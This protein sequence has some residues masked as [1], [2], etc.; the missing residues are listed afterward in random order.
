MSASDFNVQIEL[1]KAAKKHLDRQ[2]DILKRQGKRSAY[3]ALMKVALKIKAEA[4]LRLTGRGHVVT[5]RLKNSIFVQAKDLSKA[6]RAKGN[7]LTYSDKN[8]KTYKSKLSTV[9]LDDYSF[10]VGS[11][12]AYAAT[13]ELGSKP[14][15]IEA[16]NAKG[17]GTP[18]AGYFGKRVNHPG[19]AGD[20]YLYWAMKNVNITQSV[21]KDMR[22]DL[23][24]GAYVKRTKVKGEK[25]L[26]NES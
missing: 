3:W 10:A 5:S 14:H 24:F 16:K 1:D 17:L 23:K 9:T 7:N 25:T 22:D 4:Q 12:V 13:I 6:T 2:F 18:Q 11:N 19:F 20:S 26:T 8:G 15:V 21:A